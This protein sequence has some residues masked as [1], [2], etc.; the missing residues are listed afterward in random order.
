MKKDRYIL[1][2]IKLVSISF[3]LVWIQ[4]VVSQNQI[5]FRQLSVKDGLSQNSAISMVQDST[6]YL[7]IATQDGLN[8]YDGRKFTVFPYK[9]LDVTK[10]NYSN[11]G[12]VYQ[13][14]QGGLW[15]IP[16]D[17]KLYKF[18]PQKDIF[19]NF[20]SFED[21][22][23]IFQ[24]ANLNYW[25]G[26][27]SNGLYKYDP[28]IGS[29]I[30]VLSRKEINGPIYNISEL[31][32]GSIAIVTSGLL[33]EFSNKTQNFSFVNFSDYLDEA[34]N[35]NF[36]DAA[37]DKQGRQWISTFGDGLYYRDAPE[38]ILHRISNLTFT[39][40]LP[41]NLNIIDIHLD[42]KGEIMVGY[43]WT[44]IVFVGF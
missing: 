3:C 13:D 30:K 40:P 19:E 26:T 12:K 35:E 36:S 21:V 33:I 9:F 4:L 2:I 32:R 28:K 34:I 11:L 31:S 22:S 23:V 14:K 24:D 43:L 15:A 42:K 18:N 27:Y 39:D 41:T 29:P 20:Q 7:W 25:V 37:I 38:K 10:T 5:S 16:L 8:K 6:G 44:R 1:R 17:K